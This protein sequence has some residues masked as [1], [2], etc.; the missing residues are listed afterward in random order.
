[1]SEWWKEQGRLESDFGQHQIHV[2]MHL[3]VPGAGVVIGL[4]RTL[5]VIRCHANNTGTGYP[6]SV[7]GLSLGAV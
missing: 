6:P 4:R 1:M 7:S 5:I 3:R 2:T